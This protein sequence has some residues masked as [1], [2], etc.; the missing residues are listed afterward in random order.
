MTSD[1][2]ENLEYSAVLLCE[3]FFGAAQ[4]SNELYAGKD[5]DELVDIWAKTFTRFIQRETMWIGGRIKMD[6]KD[7]NI[8]VK[9]FIKTLVDALK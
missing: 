8:R 1:R 3:A 7:K 5:I 6:Q 9:H 4:N 2:K